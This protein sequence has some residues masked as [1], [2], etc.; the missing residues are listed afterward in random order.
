MTARHLSLA[1]FPLVASIVLGSS[2]PAL[3][4]GELVVDRSRIH[5][6]EIEGRPVLNLEAEFGAA[7]ARLADL[8]GDGIDE[9]AV[10]TPGDDDGAAG[11]VWI[12]FRDSDGAVSRR[13]KISSIE[14]NFTGALRP[15]DRFGSSLASLGDFDGDGIEDLAVG[16]SWDGPQFRGAIWLLMLDSDGTVKSHRKIASG[17]GGFTGILDDQDF[18]G[19]SVSSLGDLDGDGVPDLAVGA[20]ED[21]DGGYSSD[22]GAVWILFLNADGTVKSHQKISTTAGGFTGVLDFE[23]QFG[24]SLAGLGDLDGDGIPDLAVGV[25]RDDD[26][27]YDMGAVY[28]LFLNRTG[29]VRAHQKISDLEGGLGSILE[30]SDSFGCAIAVV[31]DWDGDGIVDLAIGVEGSDNGHAGVGYRGS[32]WIVMLQTNGTVKAEMKVQ[33][34]SVDLGGPLDSRDYHG[35]SV[36]GL[37]DPDGDGFHE[38]VAG[39]VGDDSH[40]DDTGATRIMYVDAT[41]AVDHTVNVDGVYLRRALADGAQFGAAIAEAGDID[42]NGIPDLFIGSPGALVGA[43]ERGAVWPVQLNDDGTL[44]HHFRIAA[45]EGG[46]VGPIDPYDAFGASI[47]LFSGF[48]DLAVG[49]PG[50]EDGSPGRGA[51]WLFDLGP[52]FWINAEWKISA[53]SGSPFNS[54]ASDDRFGSALARLDDLDGDGLE[55]LAVGVPGD[56]EGAAV[57]AGAV[58]ILFPDAS[59]SIKR[60]QMIN[61]AGGFAGTLS[62]G[63]GFGSA[64]ASIGDLDGDGF[65]DLAVGSPGDDTGGPDRGAVWILHLDAAGAAPVAWKIAPGTN[66]FT[67]ELQDFDRFGSALA[68]AGDFDGDGDHDLVVGEPGDDADG[69]DRGAAW[70]VWLDPARRV[71][72]QWQAVH[73]SS[74]LPGGT[75]GWLAD[76]DRLGVAVGALGDINGDGTRELV[77]GVPH[78]AVGEERGGVYVLFTAPVHTATAIPRNGAGVNPLIFTSTGDPVLGRDWTSEVDA[79]SIGVGGF[80]FLFVYSGA[81]AGMPMTI[82]ELLLDPTSLRLVTDWTVAY[83]GVSHHALAVPNDL[84]FTGLPASAQAYLSDVAPSGLLTNAIDLTFGF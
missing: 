7:V 2:M 55:E 49:A 38:L 13:Q 33:G 18:F 70:L 48:A 54:L 5:G 24:G 67:G 36:A 72:G 19:C 4:T 51:V 57:D 44:A 58:W 75:G 22:R 78:D 64:L 80:V 1:S 28:V 27:D 34:T 71:H 25:P 15:G 45:G 83:G 52:F 31:G 35:C 74:A 68:D 65:E 77:A 84:A 63:D 41:G 17:T 30:S 20:E 26:G 50:D 79:A 53:Y 82:G 69:T 62:S 61:A 73:D 3:Q 59:G 47:T 43:E 16:A 21:D 11:A 23:D 6:D 40:D 14:G 66:G 56:D 8:D 9:V 29:T 39:A 60:V 12:L 32:V 46:F 10:G 76:G 37:G 42:G 81:L